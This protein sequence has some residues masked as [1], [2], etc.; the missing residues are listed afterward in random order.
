MKVLIRNDVEN[1]L[2][3]DSASSS[4]QKQELYG[5]KYIEKLCSENGIR[6]RTI[7]CNLSCSSRI[8]DGSGGAGRWTWEKRAV[9]S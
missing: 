5:N 9:W 8:D 2:N 7:V 3:T 1:F 6:F 4:M